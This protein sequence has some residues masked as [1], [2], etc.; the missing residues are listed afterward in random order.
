LHPAD[1]KAA[2]TKAGLT[3]TELAKRLGV[4]ITA[5]NLVIKDHTHSRRIASAIS[6]LTGY[7]LEELW[8]GAYPDDKEA[9]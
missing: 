5:I 6:R 1:I 8:P 9:A 4:S 2:I 7:S 3:Q